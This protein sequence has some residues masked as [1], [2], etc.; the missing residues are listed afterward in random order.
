[1]KSL[2]SQPKANSGNNHYNGE[3]KRG[4]SSHGL[5]SDSYDEEI[6]FNLRELSSHLDDISLRS[7]L[8][9]NFIESPVSIART[10]NESYTIENNG[11][12]QTQN[13]FRGFTK[14][15]HIL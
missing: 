4:G 5:R 14:T 7:S 10:V 2:G 15:R 12:L 9:E 11:T 3:K 8:P 1:M 6:S 13:H